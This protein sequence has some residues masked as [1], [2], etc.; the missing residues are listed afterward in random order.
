MIDIGLN[1][2][3]KKYGSNTIFDDI[4][5]EI[6]SG[7][8]VGLIGANGSGKSTI[9]KLIM[10]ESPT[11]GDIFIR[12][13]ISIGYLY[14]MAR[15]ELN[16]MVVKDILYSSFDKIRDIENKLKKEEEKLSTTTGE[17]LDKVINRYSRLQEEYISLGGYE[18]NSKVEKIISLFNVSDLVDKKYEY[19][20][21]GEKTLVNLM[22][23][24]LKDP[25]VLLLDEPTNNLDIDRLEW[26]ENYLSNYKKTV[27]VVSH[28]RYFLD[29]VTTKTILIDKTSYI[30][31]GNY[32]YYLEENE[33]RIM[34]E[35]SNYKN[36]QK[37]IEAMKN[38]IKKLREFGKK[39]Y[40]C[41][42]NFFRRAA[43]IE[44]RLEKLEVLDKPITKRSI[45]LDFNITKRSG[46][47][48]IEFN[49][50]NI[51]N[52]IINSDL[53]V[54]YK[55][56]LCIMGKNGSGKS[57]LIKEIINN[58]SDIKIGSNV[59]IGYIPQDIE[60]NN[61]SKTV[62]EEAREHFNGSED[63]LR[64]ALYRFL[65]YGEGVFKR[66]NDLSGGERV[67]LKLFCLMQEDNNL[68]IMDEPTNHIDINTK[69]ILE[70]AL[71][72]YNGTIIFVSHDRYFINKLASRVAVIKDKKIDSYL[73]NYDDYKSK[74]L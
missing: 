24:L 40:P 42:E 31:N 58:N 10:G 62:L 23:I 59:R 33:N 35:F 63:V 27:L 2:V 72:N 19:L 71:S 26:L 51:N 53:F 20:S 28:D 9:L 64:S 12:K 11:S 66:L 55:D 16:E 74:N 56:R 37:Q 29:K 4:S 47:D 25:D 50:F 57:T 69:E 6:K 22:E 30:F 67:R 8:H 60:F 7:E 21:G 73:G 43:S 61:E 41:G 32:S 68:L 70:E 17:E 38:S 1:K 45:P 14:Q 49:N 54:K 15:S 39:A 44:K 52:L 46:N 65:F 34:R 18:V 36:Q 5:F 3:S 13:G 48:V